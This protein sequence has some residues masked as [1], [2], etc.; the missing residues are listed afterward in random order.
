[1]HGIL[2]SDEMSILVLLGVMARVLQLDS[3]RDSSQ[4]SFGVYFLE[5]IASQPG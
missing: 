4:H 5:F 2:A 1:M 3:N